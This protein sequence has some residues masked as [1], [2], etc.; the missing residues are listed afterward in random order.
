LDVAIE[1]EGFYQVQMPNGD[2][3]YTRAGNFKKDGEGYLTTADGFYLY[4]MVQIPEDAKDVFISPEG[5]ITMTKTGDSTTTEIGQ[6]Q[7]AYFANPAGLENMGR[8]LVLQ[9]PVSGEPIIENPGTNGLGTLAQGYL[10]NSNVDIAEEM[11]KMIMAQRA[12][13]INSKAIQSS[14][15]ILAMT[16]NLRRS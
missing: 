7:I 15:E 12:Y 11:I 8:N 6:I 2:M 13:E 4:P 10:E 1:G 9:T 5:K 16:N 14:D 3:G